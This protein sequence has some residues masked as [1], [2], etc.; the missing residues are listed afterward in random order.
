[1]TT[2]RWCAL[3]LAAASLVSC[4]GGS[5]GYPVDRDLASAIP[6]DTVTLAG[7]RVD[8]IQKSPVY[9]KLP[10]VTGGLATQFGLAPRKDIKE[11][12]AA[13][14][15]RDGLILLNGSFRSADVLTKLASQP[16]AERAEYKGKPMVTRGQAGV[17]AL[18]G[19]I[20]AAAPV[21]RLH[22]S[23]DRLAQSAK[24]DER[25]ATSLRS[26][27]AQTQLW[28]LSAGVSSLPLPG[29]NLGNVEK[30]LSSVDSLAAW[31]DFSKSIHV[32]ATALTRDAEAAKQLHTQLRGFIGIGRLSTPDNKPEL[33]K[34]YDAIQVKQDDKKVEVDIDMPEA[35]LDI[36]LKQFRPAR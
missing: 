3:A 26:L 13:Y 35:T 8:L 1:M 29:G 33:L 16:G 23:I 6:A 22:E 36:L 14:N 12:V 7:G 28:L 19:T 15:G 4:G 21:A 34:F 30:M 10:A 27:P 9:S 25:W 18:S 31:A 24:L 20:L 2:L 32:A 5:T 11:F 17:A